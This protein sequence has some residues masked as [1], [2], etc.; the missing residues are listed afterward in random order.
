MFVKTQLKFN[1]LRFEVTKYIKVIQKQFHE[2]VE[3]FMKCHAHCSLVNWQNI[4]QFKRHDYPSKCSPICNEGS[5]IF[6]FRGDRYLM[7][8]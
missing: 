7:I 3:V 2:H 1:K 5:L 6:V 4:L 8:T